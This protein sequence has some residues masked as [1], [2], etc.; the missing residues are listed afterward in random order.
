MV[1]KPARLERLVHG[2]RVVDGVLQRADRIGVV[3]DDQRQALAGFL[4]VERRGRAARNSSA[5]VQPSRLRTP[6]RSSDSHHFTSVEGEFARNVTFRL[7]LSRVVSVAASA[8][9][10]RLAT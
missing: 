2:A 6:G 9:T 5:T 4:C 8:D 1:R 3:A 7:R 10:S